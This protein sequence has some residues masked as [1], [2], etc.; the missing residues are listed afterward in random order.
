M[1]AAASHPAR[2]PGARYALD[3]DEKVMTGASGP[4]LR[5][6]RY[7]AVEREVGVDLV[8]EQ[9]KVVAVGDLDESP[10]HF[11][12]IRRPGRIVRIDD[13]ERTRRRGD[14]TANVIEV[15]KPAAIRVGAVERRRGTNLREDGGVERIGR[16]GDEHLVAGPSQRG[17]RQLDPFR[18]SRGDDHAVGRHLHP[19]SRA[20]RGNRLPSGRDPDRGRIAV[21][22][23]AHGALD[24]LDHVG[25]RPETERNG[26]ADVQIA[27]FAAG[28]FNFLGLGNDIADGVDEPG[29]PGGH[30]D[31]GG[32]AGGHDAGF[33]Q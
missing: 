21:L 4:R 32:G 16:D 20:F 30:R 17:Q 8:G 10:A 13:D 3:S 29:H 33:Y 6:R 9:R 12:G 14:E 23:V 5:D 2:Q 31:R 15:R 18:G 7:H 25:W 1:F 24:R 22:A 28:G 11:S 26:V 19:A 27:N